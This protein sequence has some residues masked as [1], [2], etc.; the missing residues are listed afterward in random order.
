MLPKMEPVIEAR[1]R[2]VRLPSHVPLS[3][4]GR[5][6]AGLLEVLRKEDG[7][8]GNQAVVVNHAVTKRVET[9]QNR[10]P[11]WRAE[12]RRDQRVL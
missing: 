4:E 1:T 5:G 6:E 2:L 3:D 8:G 7:P 10:G 12:R 11:T 9:R